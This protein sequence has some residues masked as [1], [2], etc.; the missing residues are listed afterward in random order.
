M[1]SPED[2]APVK[3][4]PSFSGAPIVV[5]KS[6]FDA[7]SVQSSSRPLSSE[8]R[9]SSV[10][11]SPRTS[12]A[13][14]SESQSRSASPSNRLSGS[15]SLPQRLSL[16][17]PLGSFPDSSDNTRSLIIRSFAPS[18]GIFA[19]DDTEDLIRQKGFKNGLRE[20]LRPFGENITGKVVIRDSGGMSRTWEDYGVRF[21]NLSPSNSRGGPTPPASPLLQLEEVLQRR[22]DSADESSNRLS[23]HSQVPLSNKYIASPLYQ[24]LLRRILSIDQ[25][26]PHETFLHPVACVIA[27]SSHNK[28]PLESLRQLYAQTTQGDTA[29]PPYVHP[30]FLRYYVLVH[31]EDRS[32]IVESTKLYDQ[33]KRHFGLHCH[34]LRLRSDQCVV[35][36]D[37]SV[38]VPSCE[39]LSPDEDLSSMNEN[40]A[41]IDFGT[42]THYLSESDISAINSLV[43]ELVVQSVIPFMENKV[44]LWND[45]VAS[46]RRGISGRFMSMSRR[47][48]G[49]GSSSK[50]ASSG[51]SSGMTG[52]YNTLYGF[53]GHDV[54]E[55]ILRKLAD[56]AFMLR[57]YKL[58]ASTYDLVRSD[59]ANDKAWKYHA[60]A[61]EMCAMSTLL[62]P[63]T[64]T[65]RSK[66]EAVDQMIDTACYSY[67][68]RCSDTV[69]SLRC[70]GLSLELLKSRGGSATEGA[71]KWAMRAIEL[72]LAG[73][74]GQ[75]LLTERVSACYASKTTTG[76]AQWGARHRKA[77]MWSVLATDNWL[78]LGKPAL[79]SVCLEDADGLYA[80]I[81]DKDGVVPMPEMRTFIENLQRAVKLEYLEAKG[82][83]TT[84]E[85][86][87][88]Q[89]LGTEETSEKLDHRTNRKSL[90][91]TSGPLDTGPLGPMQHEGNS[92]K[93]LDDDFE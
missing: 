1:T 39:W 4:P 30:E 28:A 56:F 76:G 58:A 18:I 89:E 24:L 38:E 75:A 37:D 80:E 66:L 26:T 46:K 47:W 29:P 90:I 27:I 43:R 48:T 25:P 52:N 32:D 45:Q 69:N 5:P 42:G 83:D 21:V 91:M 86:V 41:L 60:G 87:M 23:R 33:M 34:L 14:R 6:R 62:N 40:N 78:R 57:D 82:V 53:Y 49:F 61:H 77:A 2:A 64:S 84:D 81:Y 74:I 9:D 63:L 68:T 50:S 12:F 44:A 3:P 72:G 51:S 13:T 36:D 7:D 71:A 79:A 88:D 31:D 70:L 19:S 17:S 85:V 11:G 22:L 92:F 59:Y 65:A 10:I 54:P 55:A 16:G 73:P 67:L 15:T 35:T 8:I 93:P 20:L